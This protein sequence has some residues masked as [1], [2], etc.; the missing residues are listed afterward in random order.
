MMIQDKNGQA[1]NIL[2]SQNELSCTSKIKLMLVKDLVKN[3]EYQQLNVVKKESIMK[4][5]DLAPQLKKI[6]LS[7][8]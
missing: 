2:V 5:L 1:I 4:P 6:H 8:K 3:E 7:M